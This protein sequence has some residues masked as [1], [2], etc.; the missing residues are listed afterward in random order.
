[1]YLVESRAPAS[2]TPRVTLVEI[3]PS[4][5]ART[6]ALSLGV[7]LRGALSE[8]AILCT[9]TD[10]VDGRST[11]SA[12]R[13]LAIS[14]VAMLVRTHVSPTAADRAFLSQLVD[15]LQADS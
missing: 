1:V 6:R 15:S 14:N 2:T 4:V 7:G 8:K 12:H 11:T 5:A 3:E 10:V 13:W 9:E